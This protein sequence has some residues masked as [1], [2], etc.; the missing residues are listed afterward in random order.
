MKNEVNETLFFLLPS[1]YVQASSTLCSRSRARSKKEEVKDAAFRSLEILSNF[2]VVMEARLP[3]TD[4]ESDLTISSTGSGD[5]A[6]LGVCE[7]PRVEIKN[8]Q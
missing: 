7:T 4:S 3:R 2:V 5:V 1:R 6:M 8:Q